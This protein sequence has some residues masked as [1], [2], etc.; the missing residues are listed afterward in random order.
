MKRIE[1]EIRYLVRR[2][3]V[4][5]GLADKVGTLTEVYF[6]SGDTSVRLRKTEAETASFELTFKFWNRSE[7]EEFTT[8]VEAVLGEQ[9]LDR[10]SKA[11]FPVTQKIRYQFRKQGPPY[12]EVSIYERPVQG[13]AI[14]EL[15]YEGELRDALLTKPP[16]Y[17]GTSWGTGDMDVTNDVEFLSMLLSRE[18][19]VLARF[20]RVAAERASR[21]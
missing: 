14:A 6:L 13:L 5:L 17:T 21:L 9:L 1:R 18:P 8:P 7:N 19:E 15:E 16:W 20:S 12:W 2:G 11:N 3:S 10:G 4:D